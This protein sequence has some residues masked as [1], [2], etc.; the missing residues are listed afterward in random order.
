MHQLVI[1]VP[2]LEYLPGGAEALPRPLARLLGRATRFEAA[3]AAALAD[4]L[5]L[6][7]L[8]AAGPLTRLALTCEPADSVWLRFDPVSML[9][10]LTEVWLEKPVPLDFGDPSMQPLVA[11]LQQMLAAEGLEW[12]PQAGRGCGVVALPELPEVHFSELSQIHG[13]RL[14]EVLPKGPEARR[15]CRLIN[16]SQMVFH[17]FRSLASGDQRGISLWFWGAGRVP[18]LPSPPALR[19]LDS[20][21]DIVLQGLSRWLGAALEDAGTENG[22]IARDQSV[23]LNW[24]LAGHA[25]A[26]SPVESPVESLAELHESWIAP[27]RCPVTLLGSHGGWRIEPRDRRAFWRSARPQGF[28]GGQGR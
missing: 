23:L 20:S 22:T 3:P 2:D 7:E 15:W 10:D 4:A 25:P 24:P 11:E 6:E 19:I 16:E 1:H 17:Q 21:G 18:E 14:A 5:G 8:P 12:V 13:K 9:P 28:V 26:E 27:A